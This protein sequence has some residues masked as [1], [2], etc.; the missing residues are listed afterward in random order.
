M[1]DYSYY[2]FDADGTLIDTTELIYRCFVHTCKV[3]G[4]MDV[5]RNNVVRNI[6]RTLR[7]QMEVYFGPLTDE[8]FHVR[9][10]EHMKYQLS[11]YPQYLR[12]FPTVVKGLDML[13]KRGRRCAIVTSRRRETLDLYLR[14]T[15]IF[16]YFEVFVT[17]ENTA[18]HKPDPEPALA[19]LGLLGARDKSDA[20][21]IGDSEF[22]IEC[23]SRAG[24]DTAFVEWSHNDP[25]SLPTKPTYRI[26]DLTQLCPDNG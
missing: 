20:V 1:K 23:G 3:F 4:D 24:I 10:A 12:V 16:E 15:G 6:G 17:P 19:A 13:R 21:F 22:D 25:S 8:Q 5:S 18:R 26:S 9:A 7:N 14:K 2:L 11:I